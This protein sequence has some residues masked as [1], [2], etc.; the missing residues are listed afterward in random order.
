MIPSVDVDEAQLRYLARMGRQSLSPAA[1]SPIF[2]M[3]YDTDVRSILPLVTAPTLVLHTTDNRAVPAEHGRYLA[4]HLPNAR[5]VELPGAD[6]SPFLTGQAELLVEEIE[7]FLTGTRAPAS[8]SRMLSTLLFSD[9][10]GSTDHAS[11]VGDRA[12]RVVVDRHDDAIH[13]QIVRFGGRAVNFTGDGV[14][15]TFDGPVRAIRC[16]AAIRD[17][18]R[19][20]G[21]YVRVG[22]HTGEI[23]LRRQEIA[24]IAV[25][26]TKRICDAA[27][28]GELLVSRTVVDLVAGSGINFDDR[29]PHDLKG[30]PE[31]W[32]LFAVNA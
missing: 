3:Q 32:Q 1:V 12:W 10:V 23:E 29:G 30:I 25:H 15:A 24:G 14:V 2:R 20:I 16:G 4:T 18:A 5:F 8:P 28:S 22:I 31:P 13:R 21:L 17:A 27:Q 7:E 26:L 19:Q 9:I 11:A 6:H